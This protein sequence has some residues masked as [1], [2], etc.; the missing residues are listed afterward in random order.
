MRDLPY[1]LG[2]EPTRSAQS[3]H[4]SSPFLRRSDGST[5]SVWGGEA[6]ARWSLVF[7]GGGAVVVILPAE[8]EAAQGGDS[9]A[10]ATLMCKVDIVL[11]RLR[12]LGAHHS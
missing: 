11:E 9:A 7:L 8:I 2:E 1:P 10:L 12:A 5:G 6:I 3:A 4:G